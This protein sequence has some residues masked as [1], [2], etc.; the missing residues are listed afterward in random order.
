MNRRTFFKRLG[1]LAAVPVM[2]RFLPDAPMSD[3]D[4]FEARLLRGEKI[5]DEYFEF[6]RTINLNSGDK[7]LVRHCGFKVSSGGDYHPGFHANLNR[8]M[9]IFTENYIYT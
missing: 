2:G 6:N 3:E 8:P 7:Y 5:Q 4:M 9:G 1:M